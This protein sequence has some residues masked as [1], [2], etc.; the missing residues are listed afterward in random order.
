M[1][2]TQAK[3]PQDSPPVSEPKEQQ[4]R[5]RLQLSLDCKATQAGPHDLE[6]EDVNLRAELCHPAQGARGV[7][8]AS[9]Y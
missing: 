7:S 9:Q 2:H 4:S 6:K 1:L 3:D 8:R 5:D